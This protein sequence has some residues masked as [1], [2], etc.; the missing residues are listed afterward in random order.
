MPGIEPGNQTWVRSKN[1]SSVLCSP[2]QFFCTSSE[3]ETVEGET[4]TGRGEWI[5]HSS[6]TQCGTHAKTVLLT[7]GENP[8]NEEKNDLW[9]VTGGL[10]GNNPIARVETLTMTNEN[11]KGPNTGEYDRGNIKLSHELQHILTNSCEGPAASV[12][13]HSDSMRG[14]ET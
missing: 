10:V 7:A 2:S 12:I 13:R 9:L 14:V 3:Q 4:A 5:T 8:D 6:P 1:A 11:F